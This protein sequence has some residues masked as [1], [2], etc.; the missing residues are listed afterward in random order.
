MQLGTARL[1]LF[2]VELVKTVVR[3]SGGLHAMCPLLACLIVQP[4]SSASLAAWRNGGGDEPVV[5]SGDDN[6]GHYDIPLMR[7]LSLNSAS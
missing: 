6:S 5:L 3:P 1:R 2:G 7:S 4:C